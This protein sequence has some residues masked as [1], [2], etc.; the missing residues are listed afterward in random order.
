MHAN[1]LVEAASQFGFRAKDYLDA[2]YYWVEVMGRL[3]P[4]VTRAQVQ[5]KLAPQF[6]QWVTTTAKNDGERANLPALIVREGAGG[7]DSLR[8]QYSKPL[9]VLL[10]LVGL[11]LALACANVANLLLARATARRREM[12]LR[13]SVGAGRSRLVRQLLTESVLLAAS[14][15]ILGILFALWGIRFLTL[16]LANGEPNFDLHAQLN[17]HVMGAAAII[18]LVTGVLFGLAPALQST[19][20]DVLPALKE[21]RAGQTAGRRLFRGAGLS[22]VLVAG[23]I[24]MSLLMLV[25]AGLFVRTLSNLQAVDVGFNRENVL[26]FELNAQQAGHKDPEIST[27]FGDLRQRLGGI[28]GVRAVSFSNRPLITAGYGH[29]VSVPGSEPNP[30]NRL[31]AVGPGFFS[32]MRIPM[33]A[34]REI[35]ESDRRGSQAVA[36]IN[37]RFAKANFAGRNPLGQHLTLWKD[38]EVGRDMEVIGIS[39][40]AR[41]GGLKREIPPVAYIAYDQ[42]YPYPDRMVYEL[43]TAGDPLTYVN[44]AREIVHRADSRVPLPT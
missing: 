29:P 20:V 36:V 23:Q 10:A 14:G 17:W 33:L 35:Q 1:L 7:L 3:R 22:E 6:Q 42:G 24:A 19:R 27:F 15:G 21:A 37:E 43:R 39:R 38:K 18:S 30:T 34:G 41:Y 5:A 25:A 2:N 13:L 16:L 4:G 8:R 9:L 40:D 11:I 26:L 44:S 28:P 32:T 31:L 12:A